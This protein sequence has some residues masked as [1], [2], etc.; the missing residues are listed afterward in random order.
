[1]FVIPILI[2]LVATVSLTAI[3]TKMYSSKNVFI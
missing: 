2:L 3:L 1:M